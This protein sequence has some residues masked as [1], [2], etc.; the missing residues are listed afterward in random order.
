MCMGEVKV[1][2][3]CPPPSREFI[4]A[5]PATLTA[6]APVDIN[7]L[8]SVDTGT[9]HDSVL[10][11]R[12]SRPVKDMKRRPAL[13][14]TG[15][16][17]FLGRAF[18]RLC[19]SDFSVFG[20]TS[21]AS[22]APSGDGVR[23]IE[24][25]LARPLRP[26]RFPRRV[27]GVVHLANS[28]R[29]ADARSAAAMIRVNAGSIHALTDYARRAGARFFLYGSTG[30]VYGYAPRPLRETDVPAP[31]DDYTKSKLQGELA[32]RSAVGLRVAVVRFFFP[33]GP[34]QTRGIVPMLA[35][36]IRHGIPVTLFN[37]HENPR[38]NPMFVDDAC[39]LLLRAIRH[40]EPLILNAGGPEIVKVKSLA[41]VIGRSLDRPVCFEL[42]KDPRIGDMIGSMRRARALFGFVPKVRLREGI[43]A[44]F[45]PPAR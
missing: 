39:E 11:R 24:Q 9:N 8:S 36:R 4:G 28:V 17:G 35:D 38:L 2:R 37:R 32:A 30:G 13:L 26:G 21:D 40:G 20:L 5:G 1:Y 33:Y 7:Q 6:S 12:I 27:A 10:V 22:N 34:G 16:G 23:W 43:A 29:P 41:R 44:S 15:A 18:T 3:P 42:R 31:F 14:L 19:A 45:L 25:D